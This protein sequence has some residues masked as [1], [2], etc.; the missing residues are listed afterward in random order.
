MPGFFD[1]YFGNTG[2]AGPAPSTP[3]LTVTVSG[4]TATA[5][6]DGDAGVTNE[7]RY[8]AVG[9]SVWTDGGSRSGDGDIE[10]AGLLAGVQYEFI[11]WSVSANG[12]S[13]PSVGVIVSI[14]V[15][16]Q[17]A[18][19]ASWVGG[20]EPFN[21]NMG[22][23]VIYHP[24]GGGDSRTIDAI[25]HRKG[26]ESIAAPRG[27]SPEA[28]IDVSND[29]TTGITSNEIDKSKGDISYAIRKG[30][31]LVRRRVKGLEYENAGRVG[32]KVA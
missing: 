13:E 21:F 3:T 15:D 24:G 8:R 25:V 32:I 26:I 10:V 2:A 14:D 19:D 5:T 31:P 12:N 27:N 20:N 29:L 1:E 9:D 17:N 16:Q 4:T 23:Q 30:G 22:E 6:F 7:L 11:G 18:F 28:L